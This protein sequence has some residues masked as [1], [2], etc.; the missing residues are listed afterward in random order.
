MYFVKLNL[1]SFLLSIIALM[2]AMVF[3]C[4]P[5]LHD[6][7]WKHLLFWGAW[8]VLVIMTLRIY[9]RYG[10]KLATL[11]R[12][13]EAGKK[14]YSRRLF[15]PYMGT[16]CYRHMVYFALCELDKRDDYHVILKKYFDGDQETVCA[17]GGRVVQIQYE[18]GV[19]R[20]LTKDPQSGELTDLD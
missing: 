7:T 15:Y 14:K 13:V 19:L 18:N 11:H 3:L 2:V 5:V 6:A 4:V 12:L 10:D 9:S 17:G 1:Y 20:F 16:L 8:G